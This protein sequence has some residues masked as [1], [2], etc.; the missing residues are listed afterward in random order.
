MRKHDTMINLSQTHG[1]GKGLSLHRVFKADIYKL[2]S[3]TGVSI[4]TEVDPHTCPSEANNNVASRKSR[5][6]QSGRRGRATPATTELCGAAK[7]GDPPAALPCHTISVL[8]LDSYHE[9]R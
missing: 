5:I 3:S 1:L 8:H 6:S 2:G 4:H 7:R 9:L